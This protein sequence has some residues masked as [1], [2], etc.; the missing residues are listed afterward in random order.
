MNSMSRRYIPLRLARRLPARDQ[1]PTWKTTK[2]G[3]GL[4]TRIR[5]RAVHWLRRAANSIGL[6]IRRVPKGGEPDLVAF[7]A[8]RH[9]DLVLDVGAN[10]GQFGAQLRGYGYTGEILSFEPLEEV[11]A[12]LAANVAADPKWTA[13][14]LALGTE[15]GRTEVSVSEDTSFSS[16]LPQTKAAQA[17]D[18]AA[19]VVRRESV[20]VKPL[21]NFFDEFRGRNVFLKIDTQGFER[22]V[23]EGASRTLSILKGIQLEV[24]IVHLYE[25][26]WGL[27]QI[28]DY[29]G[30]RGYTLSQVRPVNYRR[31]DPRVVPRGGLRLPGGRLTLYWLGLG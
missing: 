22:Q 27:S 5:R 29:L 9:V 16:I 11:F 12:T 7:L 8:S 24:P 28:S 26:A 18:G 14:K 21:D 2:N 31:E 6:D 15:Q 23:L 30:K 19:R 10:V 3:V 13:R 25:N 4:A 20:E 1:L 17:F